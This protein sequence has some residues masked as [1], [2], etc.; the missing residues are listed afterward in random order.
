MS[1]QGVPTPSD[2][3][4]APITSPDPEKDDLQDLKDEQVVDAFGNEEMAEVKYKTLAWWYGFSTCS[5]I[6]SELIRD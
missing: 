1:L 3:I 5:L 2:A 4:G 6:C